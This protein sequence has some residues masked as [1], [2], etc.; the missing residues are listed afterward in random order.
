MYIGIGLSLQVCQHSSHSIG[1]LALVSQLEVREYSPFA[2]ACTVVAQT[3]CQFAIGYKSVY[4][5]LVT[6][7]HKGE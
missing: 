3:Q 6:A 5:L 4:R 2:T 1:V 7:R